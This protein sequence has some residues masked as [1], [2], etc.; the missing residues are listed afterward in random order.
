[1][2]PKNNAT[3]KIPHINTVGTKISKVSR[4]AEIEEKSAS[5]DLKAMN[6]F[7]ISPF[8]PFEIFKKKRAVPNAIGPS[9]DLIVSIL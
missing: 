4:Y 5:F 7:S 6:R 9:N 3:Q 2:S 1:M 8:S